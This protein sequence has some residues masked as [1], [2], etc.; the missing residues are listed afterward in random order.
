[1]VRGAWP[2][3]V[4]LLPPLPVAAGPGLNVGVSSRRSCPAMAGV[5][6]EIVGHGPLGL[7]DLTHSYS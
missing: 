1:M 3:P 7:I 2:C 5:P 6:V 4:L